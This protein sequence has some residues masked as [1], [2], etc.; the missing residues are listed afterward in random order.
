MQKP[1]F[2]KAKMAVEIIYQNIDNLPH[3]EHGSLRMVYFGHKSDGQMKIT[4]A[5]AEAI[6]MLLEANGQF[7][8]N[9]LSEATDLLTA[10][11]Y[12]VTAP[13][14]PPDVADDPLNVATVDDPHAIPLFAIEAGEVV[15]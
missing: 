10:R 1:I 12:T 9:G 6:V 5:T 14:D 13:V 15:L 2:A 3:P 7:I 8:C 4:R 11:G